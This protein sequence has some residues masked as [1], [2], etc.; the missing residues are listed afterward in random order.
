MSVDSNDKSRSAD[1]SESNTDSSQKF[2]RLSDT[3]FAVTA[4]PAEADSRTEKQSTTEGASDGIGKLAP[5]RVLGDFEL[6]HELGRGGMGVVYEARQRSLGKRVAVKVL[7]FSAMLDRRAVKRFQ[8][9]A[10]A[11]AQLQHRNIVPVYQVG[12]ERDVYFY[13]MQ[14][15][16][17]GDL[18]D[19]F[20]CLREAA[21]RR[22]SAT[23]AD[24]PRTSQRKKSTKVAGMPTGGHARRPAGDVDGAADTSS[25]VRDSTHKS[26]WSRGD[27]LASQ[28]LL[29]LVEK[30]RSTS[31]PEFLAALVSMGAQVAEA[32]HYAHE[33]GIVHRDVK[34]SN[35][36][37]DTEGEV[38]VADFGLAQIQSDA[39][40][41][42]TGAIVG[43]LRYMSPEQALG[44]RIGVD[45][46]TDIYS[47]GVTLY[48][49]LTL[50]RAFSGDNR[51]MI[52][53]N[54]TFDDPIRP[55]KID[56][57]IPV[58]LETIVMKA[59]SKNPADRYQTAA[60][61][62][63]DFRL[64]RDDKPI[65]GRKPTIPQHLVR[66][67][68]RNRHVVASA[69]MLLVI[70]FVASLVVAAISVN[71]FAK[72]AAALETE[73]EQK[74][75]VERLLQRSEGLRL[76]AN[77]SIELE[78]DPTRA[79]LLAVEGGKRYPGVDTNTAILE[80]LDAQHEFRTLTGHSGPVGHL[81]FN[82]DGTKLVSAAIRSRFEQGPDPAMIWDTATGQLI[83]ILQEE[84]TITSA[85][86]SPDKYR[87]LTASSP[88]SEQATDDV[89]GELVGR[90]PSLWDSIK[91]DKLLSF[92]NAFLFKAHPAVF[93]PDGRRAVLPSLGHTATIYDCVAGH[94]LVSL[95]GHDKRVVFAAFSPQGDRVV[96]ASDDN[97]VRVWDA[98]S[99]KQVYQFDL[100]QKRDPSKDQCVIDTVV[101]RA[102][103]RQL[104]TGSTSYG[105]H[106]GTSLRE[107]ES[108]TN[109][110]KEVSQAIGRTVCNY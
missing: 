1:S 103:G 71:L 84:K 59:M 31:V 29:E 83:G 110:S 49:L 17:G 100:W 47:L 86:F 50:R 24:S 88:K 22:P 25:P 105:V 102:D 34:P 69:A 98:D 67:S 21:Q 26:G 90:S 44:K 30:N 79:L 63:E 109:I 104:V 51:E 20:K 33:M 27:T 70:T 15:I 99:G 93:D 55:R 68:R 54:I 3:E 72:T 5:I 12:H 74:A 62:A 106:L 42:A 61:M 81:A 77:S 19:L 92:K 39:G 16:D 43:T 23:R 6:M 64:F 35:L 85:A 57:R 38:W 65:K 108:T 60:E 7:P 48:E 46:R 13:A 40:M 73:K 75:E 9:E 94:D 97:T 18:G 45:H 89:N 32:L 107:N 53:R 37:L 41:T 4:V 56:R 8:N 10:W 101:F 82:A 11:A 80:A 76:A 28:H 58:E 52:L 87:I 14:F 96:T 66:W 78:G 95:S 2:D 91:L 36:L